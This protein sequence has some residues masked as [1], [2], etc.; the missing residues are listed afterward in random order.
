MTRLLLSLLISV[1]TAAANAQDNDHHDF[2][3]SV[4]H[5]HE[6]MAPLVHAPASPERAKKV[7]QNTEQLN[8]RAAR[9]TL[10]PAPD[11]VSSVDWSLAASRLSESTKSLRDACA[12]SSFKDRLLGDVNRRFH[13]LVQLIGHG[14]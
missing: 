5:F 7:C 14:H 11:T 8:A 3:P 6:L 4:M 12:D 1:L 2:P 9:L 10:A 13:Q